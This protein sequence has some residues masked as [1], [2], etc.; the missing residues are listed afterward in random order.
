MKWI[1]ND[2]QAA[3]AL[4]KA[5]KAFEAARTAAKSLPLADKIVALRDALAAKQAAYARTSGSTTNPVEQLLE[6]IRKPYN[7]FFSPEDA[8]AAQAGDHAD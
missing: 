5:D 4:K 1:T 7:G 3:K 2:P 8:N 6:N